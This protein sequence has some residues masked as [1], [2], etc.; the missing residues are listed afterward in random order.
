MTYTDYLNSCLAFAADTS[1]WGDR[2]HYAFYTTSDYDAWRES[3]DNAEGGLSVSWVFHQ[4]PEEVKAAAP[5]QYVHEI[6]E[7]FRAL[8]DN[9]ADYDA[10]FSFLSKFD[11]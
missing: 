7:N 3:C 4:T 5:A 8:V 2:D 11:D 6:L 10:L 1:K 9:E